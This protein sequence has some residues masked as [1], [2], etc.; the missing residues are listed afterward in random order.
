MQPCVRR[1]DGASLPLRL[2]PLSLLIVTDGRFVLRDDS[3]VHG[4]ACGDLLAVRATTSVELVAGRCSG[5]GLL[6]H[7][8][9]DWAER[10]LALCRT[11]GVTPRAEPL[12]REA[13]GSD[14]SRQAGRMLL[15]AYLEGRDSP[16]AAPES[17]LVRIEHAGRLVE[18]VGIAHRMSGSLVAPRPV[19]AR[20]RSR[21]ARLVRALE[22]LESAPPEDLSL[23]A[24]AQVLGISERHTSRLL[25]EE[26]GKPL[27]EYLASLRI[28][29][30]K[31]LLVTTDL[32]VTEVAL[33]TGWRSLSHFNTVFRRRVGTTPSAYRAL[34]CAK[35]PTR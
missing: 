31:K 32:P 26:L 29:R 17:G 4:L 7:V 19:G 27:P 12:A 11:E 3:G 8:P 28:E 30:A 1:L 34:S 14:V 21:R 25:R 6:L 35:D 2:S 9:P 10:A 13:A 16:W 18:L 20:A 22:T 24:L 5:E 15:T 33:E 23:G